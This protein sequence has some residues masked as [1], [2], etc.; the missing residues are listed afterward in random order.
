MA[1]EAAA[2]EAMRRHMTELMAVKQLSMPLDER[3]DSERG[4]VL[5]IVNFPDEVGRDCNG[6]SGFGRVY[7]LRLDY[8]RLMAVGSTKI[9]DMLKPKKQEKYRRLLKIETLPAG[10]EYVLDFTPPSEGEESAELTASLW[11][12]DA[13]KI[14]WL[15]GYYKPSALIAGGPSIG[16]VLWRRPLSDRPVG[17]V[18]SL[19]HDDKCTCYTT[20]SDIRDLW[21]AADDVP[22]IY[23][24]PWV[25]KYREIENYCR[26]RHCM[27]IVRILRAIAGEDVLIN[28]ATRMWTL[29]HVALYLDAASLVVSRHPHAAVPT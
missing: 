15:S 25:P 18:L 2:E 19:G 29:A 22:G 27:A 24:G 7:Q 23:P 14:W 21:A 8:D 20:Y 9:A 3:N 10:V 16:K 4:S 6:L 26:V 5:A 11:L 13:T 12:P 1:L 17:A 28:S